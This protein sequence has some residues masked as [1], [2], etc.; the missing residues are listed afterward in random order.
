MNVTF[1]FTTTTTTTTLSKKHMEAVVS[2]IG[3]YN[4]RGL[5]IL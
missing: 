5:H 1:T 4:L 2:L 3:V